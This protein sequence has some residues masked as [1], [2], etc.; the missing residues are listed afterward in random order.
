[1]LEKLDKITHR[2]KWKIAIRYYGNHPY[3]YDYDNDECHTI[4]ELIEL[5]LLNGD[6]MS[7]GYTE[8]DIKELED[9]YA[10]I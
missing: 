8:E 2:L 3:A 1:M 10:N 4:K 7:V 6:I 9:Y 5:I